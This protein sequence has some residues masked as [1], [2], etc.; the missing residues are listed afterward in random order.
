MV[1]RIQS[2]PSS[3]WG[4]NSPPMNGASN[5]LSPKIATHAQTVALGCSR[6]QSRRLAYQFLIHSK[7]LFTFSWTP[8]W[9]HKEASAGTAVNV[10]MR[11][12]I[13]PNDMVSA[14]G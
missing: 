13:R 3:R 8:Y 4:M 12:P 7:Y 14:I 10:R 11:D 5:R 1:A 2:A 9:N 6:H